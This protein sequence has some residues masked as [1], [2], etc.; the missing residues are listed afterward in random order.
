MRRRSR[1]I[2]CQRG[3]SVRT[4]SRLD[5][6]RRVIVTGAAGQDGSYLTE[7]LLQEG[8]TVHALV[9]SASAAAA[10]RDTANSR[11]LHVHVFDMCEAY[12]MAE[13]L[14]DVRPDEIFNLAGLSSVAA[15]ELGWIPP[16]DLKV[17]MS[18]L[19]SSAGGQ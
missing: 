14:R 12:R 19:L 10:L 18:D 7:R 2:P 4:E 13:L 6:S 15:T 9:C 16:R 17:I 5:A 8:S 3:E 1:D 11:R